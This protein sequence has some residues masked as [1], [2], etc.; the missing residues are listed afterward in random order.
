M[1]LQPQDRPRR[2]F[3]PACG[4]G[5]LRTQ[6]HGQAR[7]AGDDLLGGLGGDPPHQGVVAAVGVGVVQ[8]ESRLADPAQSVDR[9]RPR[10]LGDGG[11]PRIGQEHAQ[12]GE[13]VHPANKHPRRRPW[14]VPGPWRCLHLLGPAHRF[15]RQ[16]HHLGAVTGDGYANIAGRGNGSRPCG[17]CRCGFLAHGCTLALSPAMTVPLVLLATDC[18]LSALIRSPDPCGSVKT[19]VETPTSPRGPNARTTHSGSTS[20]TRHELGKLGSSDGCCCADLRRGGVGAP[21]APW[22]LPVVP[23]RIWHAKWHAP[24]GPRSG[25]P[26]G[27]RPVLVVPPRPALQPS[28]PGPLRPTRLRVRGP[29]PQH[30]RRSRVRPAALARRDTARL[31]A[32]SH[33]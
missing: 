2:A 3:R 17:V 5:P 14:Q 30:A 4:E 33:R 20:P 31:M 12:C 25:E 16:G 32:V 28:R 1:P 29:V 26:Q 22:P 11:F 27:H 19:S 9:P 24:F 23:R 10:H 7:Q 6:P 13:F 21:A 15:G 18:T 8:S